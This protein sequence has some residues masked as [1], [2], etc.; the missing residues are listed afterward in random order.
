[1][2]NISMAW[3]TGNPVDTNHL[4][5]DLNKDVNDMYKRVSEN[6]FTLLRNEDAS[7]YPLYAGAKKKIAYVGIGLTCR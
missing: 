6:A 1:M 4:V 5:Q 7:I 3:R 2:L